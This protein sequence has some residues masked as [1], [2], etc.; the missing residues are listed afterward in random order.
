MMANENHSIVD[1]NTEE[2]DAIDAYRQSLSELIWNSKPHIVMLTMLAEESKGR[3]KEIVK[4]IEDRLMEVN[5]EIK[6]PTLYLIDS[7]CKNIADSCY[8]ELFQK[9]IVQLFCHTFEVSDEKTRVLMYKLRQTWTNYFTD[10]TLHSLDVQIQ[11]I[12]SGWPI[13]DKKAN[14]NAVI[15]NTSTK[16]SQN[17]KKAMVEPLKSAALNN[18][19]IPEKSETGK[20]SIGTALPTIISIN[21]TDIIARRTQIEQDLRKVLIKQAN[22]STSINDRKNS[23]SQENYFKNDLTIK[24]NKIDSNNT[25][26]AKKLSEQQNRNNNVC[27]KNKSPFKATISPIK[28]SMDNA[29]TPSSKSKIK[30]KIPKRKRPQ[31]P[32]TSVAHSTSS[33]ASSSASNIKSGQNHPNKH[34]K[35]IEDKIITPI[36][37]S[38][39]IPL[40]RDHHIS[41]TKRPK[42]I[43]FSAKESLQT[44]NIKKINMDRSKNR[45]LNSS[46]LSS[47]SS[48]VTVESSS[49]VSSVRNVQSPSLLVEEN[50]RKESEKNIS[51]SE[52]SM[53]RDYR[54]EFEARMNDANRQLDAGTISQADHDVLVREA[55]RRFHEHKN[56]P[57]AISNNSQPTSIVSMI[58]S[59]SVSLPRSIIT[60]SVP[61]QNLMTPSIVNSNNSFTN[62]IQPPYGSAA[63][64]INKQFCRLFYLD[65]ITGIVLFKAHPDTPFDHLVS[66]DPVYLEPRRVYFSGNPTK[67]TIDPGTANEQS[68]CLKFNESIPFIFT[69]PSAPHLPQRIMLGLPDR[70]LIVNDCPYK[71]Q[72]GGP[73]L[74]IFMECDRQTHIFMLSDSRPYVQLSDNPC[75]DLWG[76][77]IFE[78]KAKVSSVPFSQPCPPSLPNH[79]QGIDPRA[80]LT[81]RPSA[82]ITNQFIDQPNA[83][84]T[85][86]LPV[87][88]SS[89][90]SDTSKPFNMTS[91]PQQQQQLPIPDLNS[92][93]SKLT[94]VGLLTSKANILNKNDNKD[95][96]E[97]QQLSSMSKLEESNRNQFEYLPLEMSQLKQA[98]QFVI[99]QFYTGLQC[100]NCS[101]RFAE[102]TS[103]NSKTSRYS[104]HLDW[105]FRQNR[106]CK[107]KQESNLAT[108]SHRRPWYYTLEQWIMFKEVNDNIDEDNNT[109]FDNQS[110]NSPKISSKTQTLTENFAIFRESIPNFEQFIESISLDDDNS[111]K[112]TNQESSQLCSVMADSDVA[113]NCSVCKESFDIHWHEEEEEWRLLNAVS[114]KSKDWITSKNFHPLCL[115]DFL[116]Q[117]LEKDTSQIQFDE[118]KHNVTISPLKTESRTEKFLV[119]P[120][121]DTPMKNESQVESPMIQGESMNSVNVEHLAHEPSIEDFVIKKDEAE[122]I[123]TDN[124]TCDNE[125][126]DEVKVEIEEFVVPIFSSNEPANSSKNPHQTQLL[127]SSNDHD[128]NVPKRGLVLKMKNIM[129]PTDNNL[130]ISGILNNEIQIDNGNVIALNE[131]SLKSSNIDQKIDNSTNEDE[132]RK[133]SSSDLN[134]LSSNNK[135]M[136][137]IDDDGITSISPRNIDKVIIDYDAHQSEL[138]QAESTESSLEIFSAKSPI[139]ADGN[140]DNRNNTN[141]DECRIGS[142]DIGNSGDSIEMADSTSGEASIPSSSLIS[143]G[144]EN[145]FS[146][147]KEISALCNI[148]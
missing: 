69:M 58:P 17:G 36:A 92:L 72:F 124:Q 123:E 84:I 19:K 8:I 88:V 47:A 60:P 99:D 16:L 77:L 85:P 114:Y 24:S 50:M 18:K 15:E 55:E 138:H 139:E 122:N 45:L 127:S 144:K 5:A 65:H 7:I 135:E 3:A 145:Y 110:T 147:G 41:V 38:D 29:D 119:I 80:M 116:I 32:I 102:E 68:F 73:P 133:T 137:I 134:D 2:V 59:T 111:G 121:L 82:P 48:S 23:N 143:D 1:D 142:K 129:V 118:S 81:P 93:L 125:I 30:T 103:G 62:L 14:A 33:T 108:V 61:Y 25:I 106:R 87:T 91:I 89:I 136:M 27:G 43:K 107:T 128:K 76:R 56:Q 96:N 132:N 113:Q 115:K 94:A 21:H 40:G 75:Y 28:L 37:P 12:D 71:A 31:S 67:I 26:K 109:F 98:H 39:V 70:E 34:S 13:A 44:R 131:S 22:K 54:Q 42:E 49:A 11:K 10:I 141:I 63:I 57:I 35:K 79:V 97:E 140:D 51:V 104:R 78:A 117:Q 101:L 20:K 112:K 9:R 4:C 83:N 126:I 120:G 90:T 66:I 52:F 86:V 6:L 74:S 53:D 100:T 105:H 46:S 130:E 148:M 64:Y 146:R 95:Q